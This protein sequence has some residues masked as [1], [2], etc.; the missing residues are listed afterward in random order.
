[1]HD[2]YITKMHRYDTSRSIPS[3]FVA[4][5]ADAARGR[6]ERGT[7]RVANIWSSLVDAIRG[8]RDTAGSDAVACCV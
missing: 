7:G 6:P 5:G 2:Y 3:G 8:V 4:L 1:M